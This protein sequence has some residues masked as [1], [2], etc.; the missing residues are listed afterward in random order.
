VS[1]GVRIQKLLA[2]AGRASRRE[3]ERLILEG[4]VRVNGRVVTELGNFPT[5]LY[6]LEGLAELC[7]DRTVPGRGRTVRELLERAA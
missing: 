6:V 1:E 3:A 4:R 5:D 7:P 2:R